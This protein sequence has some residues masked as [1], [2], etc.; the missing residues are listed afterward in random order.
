MFKKLIL[1]GDE[2]GIFFPDTQTPFS[3]ELI[4]FLKDKK[5]IG[6]IVIKEEKD[7]KQ[8]NIEIFLQRIIL[9]E[10]PHGYQWKLIEVV[11]DFHIF[12]IT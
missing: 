8:H 3:T 4:D 10:F 2:L 11:D 1:K 12:G 6:I 7:D 9:E 5:S